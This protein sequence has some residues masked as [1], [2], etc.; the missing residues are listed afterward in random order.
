MRFL[1]LSLLVLLCNETR[2]D[3]IT[4]FNSYLNTGPQSQIAVQ[5]TS[6]NWKM[7]E[8]RVDWSDKAI[9]GQPDKLLSPGVYGL[10]TEVTA[11]GNSSI[12][13]VS[14]AGQT[15]KFSL[16]GMEAGDGAGIKIPI[17]GGVR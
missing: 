9:L 10:H 4:S 15:F 5:N 6:E 17:G 7:I 8:F 16:G 14:S 1:F 11:G 2:A 3:F 12:S 13:S